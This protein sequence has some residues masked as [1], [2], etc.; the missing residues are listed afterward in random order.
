MR[1]A[2]LQLFA[3]HKV[4]PQKI[5]VDAMP[6]NLSETI[7]KKIPI[8]YFPFGESI[9]SSIAAASIV[10]KVTR[11]NILKRLDSIFPGYSF[12]CHKGYQTKKHVQALDAHGK[13]L[14]HRN[15]YL[16]KYFIKK[17]NENEKQQSMFC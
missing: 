4:I 14:I 16:K 8:D 12:D 1:R 3:T 11:D 6:L 5:L 2:A 15:T 10:A 9:S 7:Y 13:S 17:R